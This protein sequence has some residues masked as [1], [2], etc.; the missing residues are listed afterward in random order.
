MKCRQIGQTSFSKGA[1][2]NE[3]WGQGKTQQNVP[4]KVQSDISSWS[5]RSQKRQ[6]R[7]ERSKARKAAETKV[8]CP[9]PKLEESILE[10][11]L[12]LVDAWELQPVCSTPPSRAPEDDILILDASDDEEFTA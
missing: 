1:E 2:R 9:H 10:K 3:H 6:R 8:Q 11:A 7:R 4:Y 5:R 12:T